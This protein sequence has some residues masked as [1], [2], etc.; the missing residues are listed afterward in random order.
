MLSDSSS[1]TGKGASAIWQH[2]DTLHPGVHSQGNVP[3][4]SKLHHDSNFA[5]ACLYDCRRASR[6][7][8]AKAAYTWYLA[9]YVPVAY[10]IDPSKRSVLWRLFAPRQRMAA[11]KGVIHTI[12]KVS[13]NSVK[14]LLTSTSSKS[15]IDKCDP[16][17]ASKAYSQHTHLKHTAGT[18]SFHTSLCSS[19]E[20]MT[21]NNFR[22]WWLTSAR[23]S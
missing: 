21:P 3:N 6:D 15:P 23:I 7:H 22:A 12:Y 5:V 2:D 16:D 8:A 18:A 20:T 14:C 17:N 13:V 4:Y 10:N 19:R 1:A 11:N 9:H